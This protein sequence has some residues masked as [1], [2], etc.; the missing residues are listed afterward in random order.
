MPDL[1]LPGLMIEG[2]KET[3]NEH[4]FTVSVKEAP[5]VVDCCLLQK[6]VSNGRK[7]AFFTDTQMFGKPVTL[8][9]LRQRYKC[10][11]CYQPHI[12][13]TRKFNGPP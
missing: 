5:P 3:D 13:D 10:Q 9:M 11:T 1:N 12:L 2:K 4:I 7:E 8:R 6:L